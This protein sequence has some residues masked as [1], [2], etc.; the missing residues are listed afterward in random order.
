MAQTLVYISCANSREIQ[1]FA[2]DPASGDLSLRQR[3]ATVGAPLPLGGSADKRLL[4]A[5]MTDDVSFQSF[6]VDSESGELSL[7]GSAPGSG[8]PTYVSTDRQRR[9]GFCAS[10][11]GNSLS[12]FPLASNGAPGPAIQIE[13]PLKRA[14]ACRTDA[15]NRW[16]LV[17][18]L[19]EDAIRVY[20]LGD[21]GRLTPSESA[22]VR[23]RAGAG[24]RHIV[25]SP[26]NRRVYCL[27][28]LDC[29]IDRF[30][31]DADRGQLTFKDSTDVLPPGFTGKPWG[32]E[33]RATPDG[34]YLYAS[35]RT[36]SLIVAFAVDD[37]SGSLRLI[38]HY[39]TELQPRGMDIAPSGNWLLAAGQRSSQLTV[40]ALD[41]ASGRL[42]ARQRCAT[43]EN[44]V[45][46][47]FMALP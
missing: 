23:V 31:F 39:P 24:P 10:Y 4:I 6:S 21:D 13:T 43:G 44:P 19:G 2:F 9:F 34:R 28:E 35:E 37:A 40:Y 36:A 45:C 42:S 33:L 18:L 7:L 30:D 46:V 26:D 1:V 20:R 15:T 12:V 41:P 5:G 14:H 11:A 16:L 38:D 47:E 27:N 32:A 3:L 22:M 17:P 25:I 8:E 29:T